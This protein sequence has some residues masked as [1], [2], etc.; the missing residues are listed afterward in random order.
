MGAVG[1]AYRGGGAA[2]FLHGDD[3]GEIAHAGA[4]VFLLHRHAEQPQAAELSP[5]VGGEFIP[6]VYVR[7]ARGDFP[8]REV[9]CRIPQ[10]VDGF[11]QVEA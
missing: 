6:A 8:G 5:Q 1:Q 2:D 3:M 11:A 9:L 7:R 10:Q 4:A